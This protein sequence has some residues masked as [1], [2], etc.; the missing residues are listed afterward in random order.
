MSADTP[1]GAASK[2]LILPSAVS[3]LAK[4]ENP[5]GFQPLQSPPGFFQNPRARSLQGICFC[6]GEMGFP[7][8]K[9]AREAAKLNQR[10]RFAGC[11][12]TCLPSGRQPCRRTRRRVRLKFERT[13]PS[14]A[15]PQVSGSRVGAEPLFCLM[16]IL[17][18]A[19]FGAHPSRNAPA[20]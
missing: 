13:S 14:R 16:S 10:F 4:P 8:A 2:S 18:K 5:K 3:P 7:S 17:C 1:H 9:I 20:T 6:S 11:E 19:G 15:L 12:A